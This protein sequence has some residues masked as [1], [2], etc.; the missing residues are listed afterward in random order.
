MTWPDRRLYF[1]GMVSTAMGLY[2]ISH[3]NICLTE[4]RGFGDATGRLA[5]P[6]QGP[7]RWAGGEVSFFA[8][9]FLVIYFP[10]MIY[11]VA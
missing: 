5:L 10:G 11:F 3:F 9:I 2:K 1:D 6:Q 4:C 7:K 8:W